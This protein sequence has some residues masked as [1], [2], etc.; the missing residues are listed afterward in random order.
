MDIAHHIFTGKTTNDTPI[1]SASML[2]AIP[3]VMSDMKEK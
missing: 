2:V 1:A 3:R